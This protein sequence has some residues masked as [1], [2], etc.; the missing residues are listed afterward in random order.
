LLLG[1][2]VVLILVAFLIVRRNHKKEVKFPLSLDENFSGHTLQDVINQTKTSAIE[3][4]PLN[5]IV[6]I[7][8]QI[9]LEKIIENGQFGQLWHGQFESE[10]VV[11]KISSDSNEC[12]WTREAEIYKT[13]L[14]RHDNIIG[15]ITTGSRETLTWLVTD[16]HN[17]GPLSDFLRI[18]VV[19]S[20]TMISMATSAA[21]GLAHLH[22]EFCGRECSECSHCSEK[23]GIAHYGLSSASIFIKANLSCA[24][25]D[26]G[27]AV[28]HNP[29]TD[30]IDIPS[31]HRVGTKRYM[32]PEVSS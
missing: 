27:L 16:C 31:T 24:I 8:S 30:T 5:D 4:T 2:S 32:A 17:N 13:P 14:M 20:K 23:M 18:H 26:L 12:L 28:R 7:E 6:S 21:A 11:V 25:G 29:K 15:L 19:D 10:N 3:C 9:Q 22:M 1:F